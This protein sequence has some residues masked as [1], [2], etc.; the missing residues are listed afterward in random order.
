MT[1]HGVGADSSC[2]LWT[3]DGF[4]Y[5]LWAQENM[6]HT[7]Q[8]RRAEPH[9]LPRFDLS[10]FGPATVTPVGVRAA[11]AGLVEAVVFQTLPRWAMNSSGPSDQSYTQHSALV[12]VRALCTSRRKAAQVFVYQGLRPEGPLVSGSVPLWPRLVLTAEV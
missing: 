5:C 7:C 12:L 4:S 2:R 11:I 1:W 3:H 9:W 6:G 8:W 10:G